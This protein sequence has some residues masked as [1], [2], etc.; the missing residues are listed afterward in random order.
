M[1]ELKNVNGMETQ[2]E[3]EVVK[4][5]FGS[6]VFGWGKKH[7]KKI[8]GGIALGVVGAVGYALGAKSKDDGC[9][10]EDDAIDNAFDPTFEDVE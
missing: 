3:Q 2:E 7:G 9:Y 1:E 4:E 6:K 5:G 10:Y 8:L